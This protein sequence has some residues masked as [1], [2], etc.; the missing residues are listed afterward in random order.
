[1]KKTLDAILVVEGKSD[2]AFLSSYL[3]CEFVTTNGSDVPES[4]ITYLKGIKDKKIIV[5]TDPDTPGKKIRDKLDENIPNLE[6]VFI[7]K[8]HSIKHGKVGVAEGDINEILEALEHRITF[9]KTSKGT[10]TMYDLVRL[11]LTGAPDSKEKR[12][13]VSKKLYL[14][15]ASAK[16]LLKRINSNNIS[17]EDI[18]RAL[19][20]E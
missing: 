17:I 5:L 4:T 13:K 20:D 15:H 3:D 9:S 19:K 10:V 1:M 18:E 16:T 11:G 12:E 14:G 2:V 7:S 8:E 6:H